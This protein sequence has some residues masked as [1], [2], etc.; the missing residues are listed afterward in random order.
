MKFANGL[1]ER[2]ER[3]Q[4]HVAVPLLPFA[5]LRKNDDRFVT[6]AEAVQ[7]R[8]KA[9]AELT[10]IVV[11]ALAAS[12]KKKNDRPVMQLRVMLRQPDAIAIF[13]IAEGDASLEKTRLLGAGNEEDGESERRS[14]GEDTRSPV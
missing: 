1:L 2:G 4:L 9:D 11:A 8:R 5:A 12:V 7:R 10:H 6:I 13:V 14:A 3:L